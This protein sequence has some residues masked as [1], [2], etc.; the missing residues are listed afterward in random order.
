MM[1]GQDIAESALRIWRVLAKSGMLRRNGV[2]NHLL[3]VA[4]W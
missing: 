1:L 4:C 3:K 2:I